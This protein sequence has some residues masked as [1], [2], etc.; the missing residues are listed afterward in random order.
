MRRC[1][2]VLLLLLSGIAAAADNKSELEDLYAAVNTLNQDQQA[3]FQQFQM[4]Q[5]LRRAND[6]DFYASQLSAPQYATGVP[7]YADLVARQ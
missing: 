3:V 1:A 4:V 7:N 2:W 5:E 6:R